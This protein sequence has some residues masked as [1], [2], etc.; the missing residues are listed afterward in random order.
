MQQRKNETSQE[1]RPRRWRDRKRRGCDI[2]RART[3]VYCSL[4]KQET[5]EW[6]RKRV[7]MHVCELGQRELESPARVGA[8]GRAGGQVL[9]KR[10]VGWVAWKRGV[11]NARWKLGARCGGAKAGGKGGKGG[12]KSGSNLGGKEE[13]ARGRGEEPTDPL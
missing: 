8:G 10:R 4:S 3:R 9:G 11:K 6:E 12:K 1:K 13:K 2:E 7:C 5:S